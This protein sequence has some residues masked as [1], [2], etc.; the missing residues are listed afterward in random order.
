VTEFIPDISHHQQ[1]I[2][3]SGLKNAGA[4]ALLARVGQGAG[5]RLDPAKGTYGTIR[6]RQ[7]ETYRAEARRIGLT[8]MPYWY[9][10]NLISPEEN[11]RLAQEWCGDNQLVWMLDHEDGSGSIAFYRSVLAAFTARGMHVILSYIPRWYWSTVGSQSLMGI[12]PLVN[13]AYRGGTGTPAQI[14]PGDTTAGWTSYGGAPVALLQFTNQATMGNRRVDCS[15]W[16]GSQQALMDFIHGGEEMGRVDD[17]S[18]E[19][20][21]KIAV[22][23]ANETLWRDSDPSPEENVPVWTAINGIRDQVDAI[24]G[25]VDTLPS[26]AGAVPDPTALVAAMA[27]NNDFMS[28]LGEAVADAQD[29][30]ARDNDLT[31]GPVT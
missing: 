24:K 21:D 17:I 26:A 20:L 7:W 3:I 19:V 10:G 30:H 5:R 11:A 28:K 18:Q 15:A 4:A 23:T 25:V 29:R 22:R 16:R 8:I 2:S 27:T 9:I 14:Y 6:D 1:G 31:T 12:P 13:S